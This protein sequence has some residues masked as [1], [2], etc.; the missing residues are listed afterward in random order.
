MNKKRRDSAVEPLNAASFRTNKNRLCHL[1]C[2][3]FYIWC[4]PQMVFHYF[5]SR[6]AL[7]QFQLHARLLILGFCFQ[8]NLSTEDEHG[9]HAANL[10]RARCDT[11]LAVEFKSDLPVSISEKVSDPR[12]R[13]ARPAGAG[14]ATCGRGS[15]DLRARVAGNVGNRNEKRPHAKRKNL[16]QS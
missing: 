11:L 15:R 7:Y 9:T 8:C 6:S 14:H 16:A 3:R 12:P 10:Q 13:V 5:G 4:I 2:S 1:W